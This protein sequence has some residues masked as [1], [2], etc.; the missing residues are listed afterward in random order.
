MKR[1]NVI[2]MW[3]ISDCLSPKL[4][5]FQKWLTHW[6]GV[7]LL[8]AWGPSDDTPYKPISSSTEHYVPT[9]RDLQYWVQCGRILYEV[10]FLKTS[11]NPR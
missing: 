2:L 5:P 10:S 3:K 6:L 9:N 8:A 4:V 11:Y 7:L 1:F